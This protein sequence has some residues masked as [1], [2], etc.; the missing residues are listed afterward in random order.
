MQKSTPDELYRL[1][2]RIVVDQLSDLI[3]TLKTNPFS[4]RMVVNSWEPSFIPQEDT[5]PRENAAQGLQ[6]LTP[7]HHD[8]QVCVRNTT[9]G[10]VIGIGKLDHFVADS[11][12]DPSNFKKFFYNFTEG[13]WFEK[14]LG[15]A[16]KERELNGLEPIQRLMLD[17]RFSMRSTDVFLGLPFNIASYAIL[18][19]VLAKITGMTAGELVYQ[20]SDVHLYENTFEQMSEQLDRASHHFPILHISDQVKSIEDFDTDSVAVYDYLHAGIIKAQVS[21]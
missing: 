12:L 6:A 4:R 8:W 9:I 18:A 21:V 2:P 13:E 3:E 20:G 7:C 14:V 19:R 1:R 16:N 15:I 5:D 11:G 10:D 17:L